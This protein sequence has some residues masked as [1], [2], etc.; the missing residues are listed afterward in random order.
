M[1]AQVREPPERPALRALAL[2]GPAPR[3]GRVSLG[4]RPRVSREE[5]AVD[6]EL[7][8]VVK[9]VAAALVAVDGSGVSF[10]HFQ[11]G[12]GPYGEPQLL[13]AVAKHLNTLPPYD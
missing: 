8:H 5:E 10:K 12:V 11:P 3:R 4:A 7:E 9:D 2:G 1:A 6:V 13:G